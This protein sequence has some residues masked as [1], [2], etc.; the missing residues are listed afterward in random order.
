MNKKRLLNVVKA[1]RESPGSK[2]SMYADETCPLGFY[3]ARPDLQTAF[4]LDDDKDIVSQQSEG[5]DAEGIQW[6]HDA[7]LDHFKI[8]KNQAAILFGR[9]GCGQAETA[10]EAAVFIEGFINLYH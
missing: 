5:S 8:S 1:L 2:F 4:R 9:E 7:I 6:H 3:S 10:E